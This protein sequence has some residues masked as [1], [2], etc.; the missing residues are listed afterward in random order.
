MAKELIERIENTALDEAAS[1]VQLFY[2]TGNRMVIALSWVDLVEQERD[3]MNKFAD[4]KREAKKAKSKLDRLVGY[5]ASMFPGPT[6]MG[7][8]PLHI[9]LAISVLKKSVR[10][11]DRKETTESE[12]I[13]DVMSTGL[14]MQ[15]WRLG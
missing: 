4:V 8:E 9:M 11:P 14:K 6:L 2:D 12:W 13:K 5:N 3:L 10:F 7:D 15:K 1:P